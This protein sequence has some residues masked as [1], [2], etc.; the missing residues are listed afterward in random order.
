MYPKVLSKIKCCLIALLCIQ[1]LNAQADNALK[2]LSNLD[3]AGLLLLNPA[4][5]DVLEIRADQGFIPASAT[6]LVTAYLALQHW[7]E[8]Y[9]FQTHFY[10]DKTTQ[11]LWVKGSGDPFLV[12]EELILIAQQLKQLGLTKVQSIA[13][14]VSLF[15]K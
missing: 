13:L 1:P 11:T 2:T 8:D 4:A 3:K 9:H 5:K 14:D 7:G 10:L 6:K 12:S 15:Q